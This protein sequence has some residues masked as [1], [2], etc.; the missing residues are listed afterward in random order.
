VKTKVD[1]K[2]LSRWIGT[3]LVFAGVLHGLGADSIAS[4]P[5]LLREPTVS[6]DQIVFVFAGDL[7]RV[8]RSGGDAMRLTS[9]PGRE[10][11]PHFS[12]DGSLVAFSGEYDGNTD[13]FV[14]PAT[15]GNPVRLTSHPGQDLAFGWSPDGKRVLFSS[16][17]DSAN[18]SARLFT[19][20]VGGGPA[21]EIPLPRA[22]EGTFSPDGTHLAYVPVLQWQAAWKRYHGGQTRPIWIATLEDSSIE[23][24]PRENSNDFNP[25]WLGDMVYFLSDRSGPV[26]L[27]A[28]D[29]KVK[30]VRQ[31]VKNEG[32][33]LKSASA[34]PDVIV[35][36]Q[37]GSIHL[38]DPKSGTEHT[39]AIRVAG[40]FPEV[41]PHYKKLEGKQ[42]TG[43]RLSTTGQRA[44]FEVR[45]DIVTVPA[46]KG[47][48]RNLTQTSGIA[49][50]DPSWS[51]D[52]KSVAYFSD[53]SGEYALHVRGQ[54]GLGEVKT[55]PLGESPSFFFAPTWSPDGKRIAYS[56][57]HGSYWVLTLTNA[58]PVKID[59]SIF[60]GADPTSLTWSPD[61]RW[62]AY[63]RDLS[64][65]FHA[66]FIYSVSEGKST[67]LTDG[68]GDAAFPVFA[69]SGQYLY[70]ATSTDIGPRAV[71]GDLSGMNRPV[72]RSVYLAVLD[73]TASS[74]LAA[75]SDEE[76]VEAK[77]DGEGKKLEEK[78]GDKKAADT[79]KVEGG[80]KEAAAGEEKTN[81]VPVVKVDFVNFSQRIVALPLPAK[82]YRG[83]LAGKSNV[84]FALEGPT[85]DGNSEEP[86][87]VTVQRF[88][89]AKR[90]TEKFLDGVREFTVSGNREK[91]LYLKGESW[92]IAGADSAPKEGEG[93]IKLGDYHLLV[94]PRAEWRQM[95]R[96]TWRIERDFLY[97][98]G[99][100]G[101]DLP[102]TMARYEP[103]LAGL[104]SRED[105]NYLF[106]EM[107]GEITI[108]HMFVG[109][110]DSPEVT[111]VKVGLLGAD[112]SVENGRY[113]IVR[114]FDGENWNP[115]LRAPLTE[116]GVNVD[117]GDYLLAVDGRDLPGTAELYSL[118]QNTADRIVVLKVGPNADGTAARDVKVKPVGN[119][120]GLRHRAWVE[121]NRRTVSRLS[122]GR[123]GYLHL[124]DTASGGYTS[125]TRYYFAQ[126][127]K[128]G[129]VVDE[130]YNHGG[131][132]A[133]YVVDHLR[134]PVM[135]YA[136]ERDGR[137]QS[138]PFGAHPGPKV[139]LINE[140]AGSGG[141]ALP[142]Y[143]RKAK[144]GPLVGKRT[145][146]GL[147]GIG[148]YPALLDGG[149]VM[150]PRWAIYGT[151]GQ[152]EV[153]NVGIAPDV[154]VDL[155]PK[156]WR[157]GHD[158]QLEKGV[159]LA[160]EALA[161]NPPQ[162]HPHPPYPN[163][164]RK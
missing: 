115:D 156:A 33:D 107:L 121:E 135:N 123:L 13:V 48:V 4:P 132:L 97:D 64:N 35:Y 78:E 141:D 159:E 62:L 12:P 1:P 41:R 122:Q 27:F 101:L 110:G 71:G 162:A 57:K 87:P 114:I 157:A 80:K 16:H 90:K 92:F 43:G 21:A 152:W 154:D 67:Q 96:E 117:V 146:G 44:V 136:I 140:C 2:T 3:I 95:Y 14:V 127:D 5:L 109:G 145:W 150:A 19:V 22:E 148:G 128:Q 143:F 163:Y 99:L 8:A 24:V 42:L 54:E 124:P 138:F 73:K 74:P 83:L 155:D 61:S 102:A 36:E 18:D 77:K 47:D 81:A 55:Y 105:L 29:T 49:E 112:F 58:N 125:F 93:A 52:G 151:E 72:T 37:F 158:T 86:P 103:Y 59:S 98:P 100:H 69:D 6:R 32:L 70:F 106:E 46:E 34:G 15:G 139:M 88:D 20:P 60:S 17:R 129:F 84:V 134:R 79:A 142:W 53:E 40:D 111:T 56:D 130:R 91:V 104:A 94:D 137:E 161:K 31:V 82:N 66:V 38:F 144:I 133:D 85:I 65:T 75:E 68:L 76:K 113:R 164:H 30:S 45:G 50:R 120:K 63:T 153:E 116:P 9:H 147:V 51:P 10:Q 89:L 26:S 11:H 25:V 131:L 149:T 160:L 126:Q 108:G 28:Y 23:K 7:W 39:V 118:F 119:E